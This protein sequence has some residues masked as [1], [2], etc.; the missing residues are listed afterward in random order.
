ME[1]TAKETLRPDNEIYLYHY[2]IS[3][4]FLYSYVS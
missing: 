2:L 1:I 4:L 3:F